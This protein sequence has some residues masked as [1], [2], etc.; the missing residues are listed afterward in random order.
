MQD[1]E[2]HEVNQ[3]TVCVA[4]SHTEHRHHGKAEAG[5]QGVDHVQNRGNKQEQ[6]FQWFS[7]TA[8]DAGNQTRN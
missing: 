4:D 8:N 2:H 3:V 7:G 1:P 6:E 5:Q